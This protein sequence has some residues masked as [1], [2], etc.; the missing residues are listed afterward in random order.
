MVVQQ[1]QHGSKQKEDGNFLDIHKTFVYH[2]KL[3]ET[4]I[5]DDAITSKNQLNDL[6]WLFAGPYEVFLHIVN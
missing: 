2:T 4:W 5:P 3:Q 1:F 6:M